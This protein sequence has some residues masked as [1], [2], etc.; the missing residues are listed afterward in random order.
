[1]SDDN[2]ND[3]IDSWRE[4]IPTKESSNEHKSGGDQDCLIC[5]CNCVSKNDLLKLREQGVIALN[6]IQEETLLGSGCG[7]CLKNIKHTLKNLKH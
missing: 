5:E 2:F 4:L 6:D 3:Q 1:M 7:S